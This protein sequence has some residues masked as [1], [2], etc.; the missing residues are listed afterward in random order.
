[1][2]SRLDYLNTEQKLHAI[3]KDYEVLPAQFFD[4]KLRAIQIATAIP[5]VATIDWVL[6]NG[7]EGLVTQS[8][9]D[10]EFLMKHPLVLDYFEKSPMEKVCV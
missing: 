3:S 5:M 6:Q 7:V 9:I 8:S 10:T 4:V 1:I 2:Y